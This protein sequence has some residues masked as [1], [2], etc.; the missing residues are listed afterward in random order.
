MML[1]LDACAPSRAGEGLAVLRTES[2]ICLTLIPA[3]ALTKVKHVCVHTWYVVG[4]GTDVP[5][6]TCQ[7]NP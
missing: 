2:L 3:R 1:S 5:S 6:L 7:V 4:V